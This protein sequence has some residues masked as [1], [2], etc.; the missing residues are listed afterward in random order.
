MNDAAEIVI[1]A[2][3][4]Y[5][6]GRIAY[7]TAKLGDIV[8]E[9]SADGTI[10]WSSDWVALSLLMARTGHPQITERHHGARTFGAVDWIVRGA[11]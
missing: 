3:H 5:A 2:T 8:I 4:R 1:T 10:S 7:R 9:I 11:A 6:D